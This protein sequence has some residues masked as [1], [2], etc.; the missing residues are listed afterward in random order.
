METFELNAAQG[1]AAAVYC[2]GANMKTFELN[3][4]QGGGQQL[5]LTAQVQC[6]E[7]L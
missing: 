1:N 5:G 3:A 6:Y 4:A 2:Q 7:D